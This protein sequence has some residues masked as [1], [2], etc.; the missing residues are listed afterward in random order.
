MI[1]DKRR[2]DQWQIVSNIELGPGQYNP[3]VSTF[4]QKYNL[5]Q[6]KRVNLSFGA[7]GDRFQ[8]FLPVNLLPGPGQYDPSTLK[9]IGLDK[10]NNQCLTSFKSNSPRLQI[11]YDMEKQ[12]QE[13]SVFDKQTLMEKDLQEAIEQ[14]MNLKENRFQKFNTTIGNDKNNLTKSL[15]IQDKQLKIQTGLAI[16]TKP[17]PDKVPSI[18]FEPKNHQGEQVGPGTYNPNVNLLHKNLPQLS[19]ASNVQVSQGP[20]K[21][22]EKYIANIFQ[23]HRRMNSTAITTEQSMDDF[24][25]TKNTK[26]VKLGLVLP[27]PRTEA[28]SPRESKLD[29]QG[30][31]VQQTIPILTS[32][33]KPPGPGA[34]DN[35][36]YHEFG[37][38]QKREFQINKKISFGSNEPRRFTL[39]RSLES[40]FMEPTVGENP[41]AWQYQL[42]EKQK[43]QQSDSKPRP[44]NLTKKQ[45]KDTIL[46]QN[47]GKRLTPGPGHYDIDFQDELKILD[48]KLSIR[49]HLGP[50]GTTEKRFKSPQFRNNELDQNAQSTY[51]LNK[52]QELR[53]YMDEALDMIKSV[54]NNKETFA[55]KSGTKRFGDPKLHVQSQELQEQEHQE[56]IISRLMKSQSKPEKPPVSLKNINRPFDSSSPRFDYPKHDYSQSQLPG[57][58]QYQKDFET[59]DKL[60]KLEVQLSGTIGKRYVPSLG[61][62]D[63]NKHSL[64]AQILNQGH[65]SPIGPGS[66]NTASTEITKKSFNT[67]LSKRKIPKLSSGI[68]ELTKKFSAFNDLHSK[69]IL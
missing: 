67:S 47:L 42:E 50:F 6:K 54:S 26:R 36:L 7:K 55:F 48:Q 53:K 22:L 8:K 30:N 68:G 58:G 41:P 9:R 28:N 69:S 61:V 43:Q 45:S 17:R 12:A 21:A 25:Y 66:Y 63:R 19:F 40:P 33:I 64:F 49:Y 34:Y 57:P 35:H 37:A 24:N 4:G 2:Q 27:P 14:Q 15:M 56:S 51:N 18:P 31:P 60:R 32:Q 38:A 46:Q 65:S 5:T 10:G 62:E 13:Q 20:K 23:S 16:T 11:Y 1:R 52:K 39:H 44:M 3:S 59:E 29:L